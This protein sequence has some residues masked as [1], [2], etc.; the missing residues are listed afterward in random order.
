MPV[1]YSHPPTHSSTFHFISVLPAV[2]VHNLHGAWFD[3]AS[4]V[5]ANSFLATLNA[6]KNIGRRV[7]DVNRM[8]LS[9]PLS[10]L[11]SEVSE[12]LSGGKVPQNIPIQLDPHPTQERESVRPPRPSIVYVAIAS[13]TTIHSCSTLTKTAIRHISIWRVRSPQPPLNLFP[14]SG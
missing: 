13:L 9:R 6:R 12:S 7:E 14:H 2:S 11:S 1:S 5:Y 8:S 3:G 4:I 10:F